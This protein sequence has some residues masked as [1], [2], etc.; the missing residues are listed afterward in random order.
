M[1]STLTAMIARDLYPCKLEGDEPEPLEVVEW[2]VDCIDELLNQPDFREARSV[3]A[4]LL[5]DRWRQQR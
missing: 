2:P 4:L 3:A 5:L 1:G